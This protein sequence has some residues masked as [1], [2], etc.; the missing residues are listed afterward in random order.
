MLQKDLLRKGVLNKAN[1]WTQPQLECLFFHC[2]P[3]PCGTWGKDQMTWYVLVS[4]SGFITSALSVLKLVL[5]LPR[6]HS[7]F[8]S[9][10][11]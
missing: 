6:I 7:T 8:F 4:M 10:S 5:W 1:S 9:H 3:D 11:A 2:F